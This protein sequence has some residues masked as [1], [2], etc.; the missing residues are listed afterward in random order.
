MNTRP[1]PPNKPA[2]NIKPPQPSNTLT[3]NA[4][5]IVQSQHLLDIK[6]KNTNLQKLIDELTILSTQFNNKTN[7]D[8]LKDRQL[9]HKLSTHY[10][11][12]CKANSMTGS[13]TLRVSPAQQHRR[14]PG[15][16]I[17]QNNH[18]GVLVFVWPGAPAR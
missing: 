11:R 5:D 15:A 8:K 14:K 2:T 4:L 1:L 10:K 6:T 7:Q 17:K 9:N 12:K 13:W 3:L 18:S 16:K